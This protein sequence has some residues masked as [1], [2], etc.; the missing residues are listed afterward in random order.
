MKG[1]GTQAFLRELDAE[2]D[3]VAPEGTFGDAGTVSELDR[4]EPRLGD[5]D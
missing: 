5:Y 1:N 2:L 4:V 3:Q